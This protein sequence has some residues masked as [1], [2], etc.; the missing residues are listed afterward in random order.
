MSD[1]ASGE[2]FGRLW[3]RL[4]AGDAGHVVCEELLRA[5]R[6]P[7]RRYHGLGHLND[8]LAQLDD[9]PADLTDR[10]LAEAALWFHD[11][12][13][14]PRAHD[15]EARSAARAADAM[16]GAGIS[17]EAAG[18]TARLVRLTDHAGPAGD[19]R[20]ALV[21]DVDLSILGRDP[22][23][24]A[25][26]ERQVRA[27]YA[28]VPERRYRAARAAILSRLLGRDPLFITGHFR[29]RYEAAA[30]RNLKQSLDLLQ[31]GPAT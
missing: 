19:P 28:L 5:Y 15:N 12:V 8:C 29:A 1:A 27:E 17:Q 22:E 9:A 11:A 31:A 18:E 6:E 14:D 7:H 20:G 25:E 16:M 24:F 23:E 2:R 26:Y 13:Y 4:G 30:R 21:C 3:R 10:D